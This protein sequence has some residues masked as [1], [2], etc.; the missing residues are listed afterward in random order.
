M[1]PYL[2]NS[3]RI[4]N[5]LSRNTL[6][7]LA[8]LGASCTALAAPNGTPNT[9]ANASYTGW[10]WSGHVDHVRFDEEAAASQG[11]EDTA[12]AVGG[13]AEYYS[14]NSENTLSLGINVLFYRDNAAFGQY[15]EDYW[16][17]DVD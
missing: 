9:P 4:K 14:S 15:V 6:V 8:L 16:G 17:D 7:T 10:S 2:M 11:I 5:L 3:S 1:K 13:A 12:T